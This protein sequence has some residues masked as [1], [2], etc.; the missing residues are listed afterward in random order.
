MKYCSQS[1]RH[2]FSTYLTF[3][4]VHLNIQRVY[5]FK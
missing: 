1:Y 4:A 2:S 3:V 5:F